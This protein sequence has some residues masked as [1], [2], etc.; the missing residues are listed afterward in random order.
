MRIWIKTLL[1]I[2]AALILTG[3]ICFGVSV[4]F[5]GADMTFK[6]RT[7]YTEVTSTFDEISHITVSDEYNDIVV[8]KAD[9]DS[10]KVIYC[11][12][13][14]TGYDLRV[15]SGSLRVTFDNKRKLNSLIS[16][17]SF[18]DN[19][20]I[21]ELPEESFEYIKLTT[22]SGDV[23]APELQSVETYIQST[24]GDITIGG[25]VGDLSV[26]TNSGDIQLNSSTVAL[27]ASLNSTSGE[28]R[29]S[30]DMGGNLKAHSIS[31]EINFSG[32]FA[33]DAVISTTSGDVDAKGLYL[34]NADID[35]TSGDV[36]LEDSSCAET[37]KI[38]TNS[39]EISLERV[40]ANDYNLKTISGEIKADILSPKLYNI[41]TVSGRINAPKNETVEGIS[42][43]FDAKT[44]SGNVT[45]KIV[46]Q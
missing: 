14:E 44:T 23:D 30:G 9:G 38:E 5:G 7:N 27:S 25:N 1:I 11:Q 33:T 22:I 8:K 3:I 12:S 10:V 26:K 43:V 36:E 39:G 28:I 24:S 2:S 32:C 16:F 37:C 6:K 15:S 20:L 46:A 40:D 34:K 41:D 45:V 21:L 18:D 19:K 42:G 13:E 4:A 29:V 31:G 17:G 35:T